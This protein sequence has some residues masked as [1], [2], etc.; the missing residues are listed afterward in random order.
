[1]CSVGCSFGLWFIHSLL[2]FAVAQNTTDIPQ[3]SGIAYFTY[4]SDDACQNFAGMKALL[5]NDPLQILSAQTDSDGND[6]SCVD[7]MAC[8]YQPQGRTCQGF[9]VAS[10]VTSVE[11][12]IRE[13]GVYECDESN[14]NLGLPECSLLDSSTCYQSSTFNCHFRIATAEQLKETPEEYLPPSTNTDGLG[15]YGFLVYFNDEDCTNLAGLMGFVSDNPYLLQG[16]GPDQDTV[17]QEQMACYLFQDGLTCEALGLTGEPAQGLIQV[18]GEELYEC[19]SSNENLDEVLCDII[20]PMDCKT[21]SVYSCSFHYRSA[22]LFAK[23]PAATIKPDLS[24]ADQ[25]TEIAT[26]PPTDPTI[27]PTAA[28]DMMTE[29]PMESSAVIQSF[30]GGVFLAFWLGVAFR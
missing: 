12:D 18:D 21:S 7:A 20:D 3:G 29:E 19:D 25:P 22:A 16:K 13:D 28:P 4:F 23:D 1:M 17:C 10:D 9:G 30:A 5:A 8:L 14:V 11:I 6:I 15:Q 2:L 27:S 26:S 24:T